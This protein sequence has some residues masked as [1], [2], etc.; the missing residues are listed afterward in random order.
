[1]LMYGMS[2]SDERPRMDASSCNRDMIDMASVMRIVMTLCIKY[3]TYDQ[4]IVA[5]YGVT[6]ALHQSA[7]TL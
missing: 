2:L 7:A 5:A 4:I 3:L 6:I 1:M